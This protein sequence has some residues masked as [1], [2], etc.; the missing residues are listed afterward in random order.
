MCG[1][2]PGRLGGAQTCPRAGSFQVGARDR[3]QCH[4]HCRLHPH[5]PLGKSD[6]TTDTAWTAIQE[7]QPWVCSMGQCRRWAGWVRMG[8]DGLR[9]E[10][11]W[12]GL[13]WVGMG[14]LFEMMGIK[15]LLN[16]KAQDVGFPVYCWT[17]V[18]EKN[19]KHPDQWSV[20]DRIL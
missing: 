14:P 6:Q 15:I 16:G 13:R 3:H 10:M 19:L 5:E 9:I 20:I 1:D 12:T 17:G 11:G 18:H 4:I 7:F 8:M 2:Q